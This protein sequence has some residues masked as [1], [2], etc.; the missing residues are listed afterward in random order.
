MT[1]IIS[2]TDPSEMSTED[3]TAEIDSF[4]EL[5]EGVV[6]RLS[7]ILAE[8]RRRRQ[9]HPFFHHSI[10]RF[11]ESIADRRLHPKAAIIL[12]NRNMIKAVIPLPHEQQLELAHG[13]KLRIAVQRE[14]GSIGRDDVPIQR[15]DARALCRVFGPKGI[16][17]I[18]EQ[19]A[20]IREEGKIERIGAITILKGEGLFKVGNQK[21]TPEEIDR[22][23]RQMGYRLILTRSLP[24]L[25]DR[26]G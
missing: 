12:A 16:R 6:V 9:P 13:K 14:D 19:E 11:W 7:A 18:A 24:D 17:S 3:L 8:L 20:M 4:I 15:M 21:L 5:A 2:Q 10:L 1:Y 22:A 23:A 26:T 25:A